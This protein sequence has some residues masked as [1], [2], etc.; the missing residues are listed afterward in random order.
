MKFIPELLNLY[1]CYICNIE[2]DLLCNKCYLKLE[3]INY[4]EKISNYKLTSLYKYNQHSSKIL[5]MAK[6]PP[7]Y[8]HVLKL[9]IRK[10]CPKF[11]SKNTIFCPVPLSSL[12]MF[13]R[14][15]NQAEI[16]ASE[17]AKPSKG[18]VFNALKRVRDSKPLFNLDRLSRKYEVENVF[19][20]TLKG[21]LIPNKE[22]LNIVLVD[23][24]VT[25]GETVKNC[26]RALSSSGF[27][28][29]EIFSL[30]RA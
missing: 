3:K 27:K 24:L 8:F 23:D 17:L 1:R 15:F 22:S 21:S 7:Y 4:F 28:N 9:L 12:K 6:Y 19:R 2:S 10:S 11:G 14:K 13:E 18:I 25:T 20:L 30:F 26:L 29:I 16:I 5:L